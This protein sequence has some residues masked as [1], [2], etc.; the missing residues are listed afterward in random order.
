MKMNR[1]LLSVTVAGVLGLIA[2]CS[3]DSDDGDQ[4]TAGSSA[5]AGSSGR[6]GASS[7]GSNNSSGSSAGGTRNNGGSSNA[8]G[9]NTNSGGFNVA[10]FA[11]GGAGLDP[12][13]FACDPVP[14]TGS[15][16][17]AGTQPCINGTTE[18]CYCQ[19]DE[20]LCM[21]VGEGAGGAGPGGGFGDIEC[22]ATKPM[23]GGDCGDMAGFCPYG[24]GQFMGCACYEGAWTCN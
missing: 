20:W 1:S 2:S 4:N 5:S 24:G 17:V 11:V 6:A 18:V 7:G 23:N 22:P 10:G 8:N 16:C 15:S 21:D 12:D 13:D 3:S 14:E 19:M 9:G